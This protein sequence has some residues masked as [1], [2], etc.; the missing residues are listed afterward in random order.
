VLKAL[1]QT[2]ELAPGLI[3]TDQAGQTVWRDMIA[4][5]LY[6]FDY[7]HDLAVI[8]HPRGRGTP[9][10]M[11]PRVAFGAPIAKA[12]GVPTWVFRER[13][14]AGESV[15]EIAADFGAAPAEIEAA[16]EFEAAAA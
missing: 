14:E 4:R 6:E 7:D 15:P 12:S 10:V 11:D 3:A 9:I 16:L 13:I 5:R 2:D 8:W 1:E